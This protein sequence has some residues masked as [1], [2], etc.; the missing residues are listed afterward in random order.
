MLQERP[1][2]WWVT[3]ESLQDGVGAFDE[4]REVGFDGVK[5]VAVDTDLV[6]GSVEVMLVGVGEVK[7]LKSKITMTK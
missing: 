7:S 6:L 2:Q 5:V 1:Q 4:G 3:Y